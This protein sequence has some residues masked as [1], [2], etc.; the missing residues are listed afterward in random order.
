MNNILENIQ[1]WLQDNHYSQAWLA[2]ELGISTAL[3]SQ[4]LNGKRKLQTKYVIQIAKITHESVAE[5][6]S[7]RSNALSSA[8]LIELRGAFSSKQ[9]EDVFNKTVWD[10]ERYTDLEASYR[11]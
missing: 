7:N 2:K 5:L 8:P 1:T 10:I 3:L 6:T 4:M 9:S 11:E